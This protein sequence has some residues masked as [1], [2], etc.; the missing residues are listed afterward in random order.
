MV[1]GYY[2]K[3]CL[4]RVARLLYPTL[5]F[6]FGC[7][8]VKLW[9]WFLGIETRILQPL[10]SQIKRCA[11]LKKGQNAFSAIFTL[12]FTVQWSFQS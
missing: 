4:D 7:F 1:A 3:Q 5:V 6:V 9:V 2:F 10:L 11:D 12:T 8:T